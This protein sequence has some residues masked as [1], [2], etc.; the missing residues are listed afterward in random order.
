MHLLTFLQ[1]QLFLSFFPFNFCFHFVF[2]QLHPLHMEVPRIGVKTELQLPQPQLCHRSATATATATG[3]PSCVCNLL[4]SS[5]QRRILNPLSKGRDQTTSSWIVVRFIT[6]EPQ[7]ETPLSTFVLELKVTSVLPLEY[8][9]NL[10]LYR[11]L[12]L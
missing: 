3:D 8:Y 7:W 5:W 10:C 4:Y 12:Y 6:I 1:L 9:C 11:F 2:F